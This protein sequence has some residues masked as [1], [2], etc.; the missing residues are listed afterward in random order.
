M[1]ISGTEHAAFQELNM[2]ISE[3]EYAAF[4]QSLCSFRFI[5]YIN[6]H[7][8]V[9]FSDRKCYTVCMADLCI[10]QGYKIQLKAGE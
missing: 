2:L 10:R 1:L 6:L 5:L 3:T 4:R 9:Y 7:I 8:S